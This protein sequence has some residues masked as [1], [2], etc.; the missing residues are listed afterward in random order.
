MT[1]QP[2]MQPREGS[3][4]HLALQQLREHGRMRRDALADAI[5]KPADEIRALLSYAIRIGVIASG[6]DEHGLWFDV[7]DAKPAPLAA[8]PAATPAASQRGDAPTA[9]VQEIPQFLPRSV[10]KPVS[11]ARSNGIDAAHHKDSSRRGPQLVLKAEAARPDATDR[12]TPVNASPVGGP[13]GAGQP[14]AAG[15]DGH[16]AGAGLRIALWSDGA[17]H[18]VGAG[19]GS[20]LLTPDETRQVVSYLDGVD[21]D[22]VRG[23]A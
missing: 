22:A 1:A 19:C 17:L 13:M 9:L 8:P 20:I 18:I 10:A 14:A 15:P 6:V 21:L 3:T 12:G 23:A 4:T 11:T 16:T 2:S 5:E 7:G